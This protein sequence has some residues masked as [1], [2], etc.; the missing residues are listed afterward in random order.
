[1]FDLEQSKRTAWG[2]LAKKLGN[3]NRPP[4]PVAKVVSDS[5]KRL[6]Q[7]SDHVV[8]RRALTENLTRDP[9]RL[10]DDEEILL[11]CIL[12]SLAK[13]EVF[14]NPQRYALLAPEIQRVVNEQ[15]VTMSLLSIRAMSAD[16]FRSKTGLK[17]SE[18]EFEFF[19]RRLARSARLSGKFKSYLVKDAEGKTRHVELEIVERP[20]FPDGLMVMRYG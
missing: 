16:E 20:L 8:T 2:N 6:G 9:N 12:D 10:E 1:M 18:K 14:K 17:T 4:R 3:E 7:S 19:F 5:K 15:V 13:E 11:E